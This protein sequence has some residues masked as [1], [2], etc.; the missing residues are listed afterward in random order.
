MGSNR[1][2]LL[3]YGRMSPQDQA[4]FGR[5]LRLNTV[6]GSI[7]AAGVGVFFFGWGGGWRAGGGRAASGTGGK[8][9][10]CARTPPAGHKKRPPPFR[11][12]ECAVPASR[13][14]ELDRTVWPP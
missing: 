4:E 9:A 11:R 1:Q 6:V 10:G 3:R 2:A 14:S 5:W 7:L 8:E 13:S 12:D